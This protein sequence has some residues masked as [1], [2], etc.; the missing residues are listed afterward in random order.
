[1]IT[2]DFNKLPVDDLLTQLDTVNLVNFN[3]RDHAK[4]DLVYTNIK[5]YEPATELP[6]ISNNDHCC[7]LVKG[8][9]ARRTSKYVTTKKRLITPERKSR[10]LCDLA[11]EN[12]E[13]V[14]SPDVLHQKVEALHSIVTRALDKHCPYKVRKLRH[15]RPHWITPGIE[16]LI[17]ARE[18]AHKKKCKSWKVLRALVQRRI[19]ASKRAFITNQLN[20]NQNT[21]EWWATL[22]SITQPNKKALETIPTIEG[23]PMT[24]ATFCDKLNDYYSTVGGNAVPEKT[25]PEYDDVPSHALDPSSI[26]EVKLLLSRLDPTKAT[27]EEDYPT[28]VSLEGCEDMCIPLTDIINCMLRTNEFPMKW[29]RSQIRPLPKVS[30]PTKCKDYRPVSLLFHLG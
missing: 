13:E 16:K 11:C 3:T 9:Y 8:T 15:D 24:A 4:L 2:G 17:R 5:E 28:W 10:V 7:I 1:M 30:C 25:T 23:N 21:K 18:K 27:T 29:K 14:L 19:R 26:G 20:T 22:K 12:W 6:P